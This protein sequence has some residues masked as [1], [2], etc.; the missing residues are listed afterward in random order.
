MTGIPHFRGLFL[1]LA[2]LVQHITKHPH[3]LL[4]KSGS[5]SLSG[6]V[7]RSKMLLRSGLPGVPG[8]PG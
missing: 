2:L 7:V 8:V 1:D 3:Y 6:I 5:R 4:Q